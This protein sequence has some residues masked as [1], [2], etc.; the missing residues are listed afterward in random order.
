M[1][2]FPD[3]QKIKIKICKIIIAEKIPDTKKLLRLEVDL[4]DEKRQIIAGIANYF[5]PKD[6]IGKQV[7]VI[8]NLE[9]KILHGLQSQGMI[10]IVDKGDSLSLLSPEQEVPLGSNV[11]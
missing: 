8:V 3:F 5:D 2:T 10:L 4:G 6:L 9:P 11:C 1:I 7:P